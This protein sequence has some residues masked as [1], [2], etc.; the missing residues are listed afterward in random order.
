LQKLKGS[1]SDLLFGKVTSK[2]QVQECKTSLGIFDV[3]TKPKVC[4][5]KLTTKGRRYV[6]GENFTGPRN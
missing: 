1:K 6:E 3:I 5:D 2:K 4:G